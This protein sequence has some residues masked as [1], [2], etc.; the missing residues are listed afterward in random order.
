MAVVS[1]PGLRQVGLGVRL[2]SWTDGRTV[3]EPVR[4]ALR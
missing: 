2:G 1:R 3:L 4:S